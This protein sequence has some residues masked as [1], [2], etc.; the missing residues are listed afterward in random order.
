MLGFL[1]RLPF[2]ILGLLQIFTPWYWTFQY[3]HY[4]FF[5]DDEFFGERFWTANFLVGILEVILTIA[6]IIYLYSI[7]PETFQELFS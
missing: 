6:V 7:N 4:K 3:I 1:F 2:N 5:S